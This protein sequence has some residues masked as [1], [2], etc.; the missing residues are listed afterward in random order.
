MNFV[1]EIAEL[2]QKLA[3]LTEKQAKIEA[4][5]YHDWAEAIETFFDV[6]EWY[7]GPTRYLDEA[8]GDEVPNWQYRNV[9]RPA[10]TRECTLCGQTQKTM[11]MKPSNFVPDFK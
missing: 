4:G 9:P 10:W 7:D 5:C 8:H 1:K 6:K 2:T 11:K 3:M